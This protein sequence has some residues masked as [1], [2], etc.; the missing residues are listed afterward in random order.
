MNKNILTA[1]LLFLALWAFHLF[2][3]G[4]TLV[5]YRDSGE[6]AVVARTL[7]VAHPPG[8]PLYALLGKMADHL[9]LGNA[10]YRLNLLSAL[11]AALAGAVLFFLLGGA[12]NM[13]VSLAGPAL[14]AGSPVFRELAAVSEMYAPALLGLA[15]VL[16]WA[17]RCA[18]GAP[19]R[20]WA[21]LF[22]AA[23]LGTGL[24]TDFVLLAPALAFLL[25]RRWP[26]VRAL[27]AAGLLGLAG[28][29]VFLFLPLRSAQQPWVDWNNPE[30]LSNL[31]GSLLRRS[32][33]GTLDLLSKSYG[34]GENFL[35][36]A[37]L[38]FQNTARAFTWAGLPLALIGLRKMWKES[39]AYLG[40][41]ALVFLVFGPVFLF[42]ANLPPNPHAVAIVEAHY[43]VPQL[44]AL[45]FAAW[46]LTALTEKSKGAGGRLAWGLALGLL[47]V[48]N[49]AGHGE[50]GNKRWNL[51][52]RD[53]VGNFFR[54]S[55]PGSVGVA[56]EDVQLFSFWKAQ[57]LDKAR[58]DVA[59]V[60]QG[61]AASPWYH[62]MLKHQGVFLKPMPL[63][64]AEDW[65]DFQKACG[66]RPLWASGDA[67]LSWKGE[68]RSW[69]LAV[70][71][72]PPREGEALERTHPLMD[73]YVYRGFYRQDR[74]PD[75]F[76]SDLISEYSRAALRKVS[77]FTRRGDWGSAE[78]CL[79]LAGALDPESPSIPFHAGYVFFQK[80][81]FSGAEAAYSRSA[82][83]HEEMAR[84][85][86]FYKTLPDV[87][88][89]LEKEAAEVWVHRGVL[90]EKRGDLEDAR[91]CYERAVALDPGSSQAH[92]N[93]AVTYWNRD[94]DRAI[95]H[96]EKALALAPDNPQA[97]QFL[98]KARRLR[99]RSG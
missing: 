27:L 51:Y 18:A 53:Y 49:A 67:D 54:S 88:Q 78:R 72:T 89:G 7:G 22:F 23:G 10:A 30:V 58:P 42:L 94:W 77:S 8:Y 98:E 99:G 29:S 47:V 50:R 34:A 69:G 87:V 80:G 74:A 37:G 82:R 13:P 65:R 12:G 46:G 93:W 68:G 1:C 28:V 41:L 95:L 52:A 73:F 96:L 83:L 25:W 85:A 35:S 59:V 36:Q 3:A 6:M 64:S 4:G 76:A 33:G 86:R 62:E 48:A 16:L 31:M 21:L 90:A 24:R 14:W 5:P 45:L 44:A 70:Y 84:R 56:K 79:A 97:R 63:R 40:F 20:W 57:M 92:Y 75:F 91:R 55:A 81:D 32:H 61:L 26:G 39:P 66:D 17:R 60:A 2:S 9:P 11:C 19:P 71:L 43:L 15:L 38:F